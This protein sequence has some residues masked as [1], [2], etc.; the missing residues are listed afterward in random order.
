MFFNQKS[1]D[2]KIEFTCLSGSLKINSPTKMCI[3]SPPYLRQKTVNFSLNLVLFCDALEPMSQIAPYE[4]TVLANLFL[5]MMLNL[6]Q[7]QCKFVL[8]ST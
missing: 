6:N 4:G 3:K 7:I 5:I 2:R 8:N 1:L